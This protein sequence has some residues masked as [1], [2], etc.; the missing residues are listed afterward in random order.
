MARPRTPPARCW[1][2][3][4]EGVTKEHVWAR[5]L[6]DLFEDHGVIRHEYVHPDPA[7]APRVKRAN[8]FALIS[9][10]FCRAC[11][12]GWMRETDE[13]ARPA[14]AAFATDEPITLGPQEQEQLAFWAMKTLLALLTTEHEAFRFPTDDHYRELFE[15]R[16][17]L[18]G[19]QVW[20]G[21][22]VHGEPAWA[23]SHTLDFG[24]PMA[25]MKGFGASMSFGYAV[26]H[27]IVHGSSAHRIQLRYD[28]HRSLAQI[29]PTQPEAT[30]PP[31]LR[32]R[33]MDLEPL[34]YIINANSAWVPAT[35]G[36]GSRAH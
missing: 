10:K 16:A 1:F 31:T 34:A 2:C 11:N 19:S 21:A 24:E 22:N 28:A 18:S 5:S 36:P 30:W 25:E 6:T 4:A 20:L 15:S 14:L 12:G 7:M 9:R 17:P 26:M 23:G 27:A 33:P 32:M 8:S 35:I 13:A 29:W 3:G